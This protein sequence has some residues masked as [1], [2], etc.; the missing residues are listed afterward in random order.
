MSP[1]SSP[2]QPTLT[3]RGLLGAAAAVG[4]TAALAACA[5]GG[6]GGDGAPAGSGAGA[7]EFPTHIPF[8]IAGEP[9]FPAAEGVPAGY[10]R[11]PDELLDL[12]PLPLP[13]IE[14]VT[15]LLQGSAPAVSFEKNDLYQQ[16][17]TDCGAELVP[18][19]GGYAEYLDK[20]QV[21]IASDDLPDLVM[22]T[23]VPR[24]PELLESKFT[25]L[26]DHLSGDNVAEYPGLASISQACWRIPML[27][28][29]IWGVSKSRPAAEGMLLLARGELLTERGV[30]PTTALDSGEDFM[31]LLAELSDPDNRTFAMGQDPQDWL[32]RLLREMFGTPNGWREVDGRFVHQYET[33]E[34][35]AAIEQGQKIWKAGYL[36][37]ESFSHPEALGWWEAGTTSL[38]MDGVAGWSGYVRNHPDWDVHGFV[39]PRWDGGGPATKHLADAGYPSYVAIRK[40]KSPDRVR[41]LLS[42]MNYIAA[43]FG[44][45]EWL[46]V[47]YG[48]EGTTYT[49]KDGQPESLPERQ[50]QTFKV[51]YAGSQADAQLFLPDREIVRRQHEYLSTVVPDGE[52][53]ASDGLYSETAGSKA[54]IQ[55]RKVTDAIREMIQDRRSLSEWP[56]VAAEW[57]RTVGDVMREEYA[58][59]KAQS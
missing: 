31:D 12:G 8:E 6:S 11:L 41:E 21:T 58:E 7:G 35:A 17:A 4:G 52:T 30:D 5:P 49:L 26:T 19:Y 54:P 20:F 44:T 9:E 36:H 13:S 56:D 53:D 55:Q 3:R 43:P 45:N 50:Q 15:L 59:A 28:G 42:V 27:N 22:M 25:D 40:Q 38:L 10:T 1:S 14:P 34:M 32:M 16:I 33:P 24:L 48:V 2:H 51:D 46:H 23:S 57:T 29:R 18:T 39:A 37:P 47:N